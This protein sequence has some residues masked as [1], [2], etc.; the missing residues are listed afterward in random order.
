MIP[1]N[2]IISRRGN[3]REIIFENAAGQIVA[4]LNDRQFDRFTRECM[5]ALGIKEQIAFQE[6][7]TGG[8][9][10]ADR[11]TDRADAQEEKE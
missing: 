3:F 7:F 8:K 11:S 1:K 4:S 6:D 2:W 5:A 10:S 9:H